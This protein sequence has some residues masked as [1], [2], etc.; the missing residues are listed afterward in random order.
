[1]PLITKA[2]FFLVLKA[3]YSVC[4]QL[5][6]KYPPP[7][8][9]HG[10]ESFVDDALYLRNHLNASG[11]AS[12]IMKYTGKMPTVASP[13]E[14]SRSSTPNF[15][16]FNSFKQRGFGTRS[17]LPSPS[18][19]LQQQ[20]G[21]EALFQGA[22]KGV[23]ER[24]EKL[25]INQAVRDAVGEIRRNINE[26]RHPV[27][28]P[29]EVLSEEGPIKGLAALE[30]RN[31]QLASMLEETVENL[32]SLATS[33]L[34]DKAKSLELIEVAA[35]KIQFVKI[36]LEDS[37]M[38]VPILDSPLV[39]ENADETVEETNANQ[40]KKVEDVPAIVTS[41]SPADVDIA[42][43][44]LDEHDSAVKK[45]EV[46]P[47]P[48]P[49]AMD[50][51]DDKAPAEPL[52]TTNSNVRPSAPIPT[53]S[54]LAQS[55]FSWML[56]PDESTSTQPHAVATRSPPSHKKRGPNNA[57][58]ERNAFLFGEVPGTGRDPL[59]S[60]DIFGL[61]PMRKSKGSEE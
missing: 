37:S 19:F 22:A 35:A 21:I 61:Q 43:L 49:D 27:K 60:D 51:S 5:L 9:P 38:E 58:R 24:G 55:S 33:N 41:P 28:S 7:A 46:V 8:P 2:D 26:S 10:P 52:K 17:P 40:I 54:T 31:Q 12:L 53:R 20:G 18:R 59:V 25:G 47:S 48:N 29:R 14:T 39:E 56:E 23:L 3:D 13:S 4:L 6:L 1:M 44:K 30:K 15:R 42:A 32:K 11:G 45:D 16:G 36:Y 57:S 50:T 34:D